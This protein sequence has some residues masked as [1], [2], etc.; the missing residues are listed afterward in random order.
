MAPLILTRAIK[1]VECP[2]YI[3]HCEYL[4]SN[5]IIYLLTYLTDV[6]TASCLDNSATLVMKAFF[7]PLLRGLLQCYDMKR[8]PHI[9]N[10]E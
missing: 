3:I 8:V 7:P 4:F 1:N 5:G 2:H 6:I 9:D 10:A